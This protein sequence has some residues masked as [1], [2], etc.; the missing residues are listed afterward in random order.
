M[1]TIEKYVNFF[2][3]M[4]DPFQILSIGGSYNKKS[5]IARLCAPRHVNEEEEKEVDVDDFFS[6]NKKRKKG[7]DINKPA[8]VAVTNMVEFEDI[9]A[10][11]SLEEV[12][13]WREAYG[14][15]IEG[16]DITCM[17]VT[18]FKHVTIEPD[19]VMQNVRKEGWKKPTLVQSEAIPLL[20]NGRDLIC[21]APTGS[22]KTA[23]FLVPLLA[24]LK[25]HKE[26]GMRALVLS[27]TRELSQQTFDVLKKLSDGTGI[28]SFL[29]NNDKST[30][31]KRWKNNDY[32]VV[33]ATP[34][35]LLNLL[36]DGVVKV[37]S[38]EFLVLDEAD[39]LFESDFIEQSDSLFHACSNKN[40]RKAMFS[41]TLGEKPE[42]LAKAIM[43]DP[44]TV[45][46]GG[47]V[48]TLSNDL[49]QQEL[50]YVGNESGKL[51]HFRSLLQKGLEPPV[52]I[53]TQN[54]ERAAELTQLLS[55]DNINVDML[56][57]DRTE[58]QRKITIKQFREGVV[59]VL[60][61]TD[62]LGRGLD[63]KAINVIVNWDMPKSVPDYV[64]RVGRTGR[65]G[66]PGK[67]YSYFEDVD[68]RMA[69]AVAHLIQNAGG[70]APAWLLSSSTSDLL[71]NNRKKKLKKKY[72]HFKHPTL[73][74]PRENIL[75]I[76]NKKKRK[77]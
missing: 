35:R 37:D 75:K 11:S 67:V 9:E 66:R 24:Q 31:P 42:R 4:E 60:I 44:V 57:S 25:E 29:V 41:A 6:K 63:F 56:T 17:P 77:K 69:K 27:P 12:K 71:S 58:K 16:D 36:K 55:Y 54:R 22:G 34:M 19:V 74:T 40:I 59:W 3:D 5:S 33:I 64:H 65:A 32:D 45:I 72:K 76:K 38:V 30:N 62:V 53:F 26:G 68:L 7:S 15:K 73:V 46:I 70:E 52:L 20:M 51:L 28:R 18:S 61:S 47:R 13:N 10:F 8:T 48:A 1:K 39:R 14:V 43:F 50:V 23:A 2:F 21:C 49:I